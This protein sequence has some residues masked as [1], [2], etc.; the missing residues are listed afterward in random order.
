MTAV[1]A[2][3]HDYLPLYVIYKNEAA[4]AVVGSYCLVNECGYEN[5]LEI[6]LF[7]YFV[8][9]FWN[10]TKLGLSE[11]TSN[12]CGHPGMV[13]AFVYFPFD[14]IILLLHYCC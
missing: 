2:Q 9:L 12:L 3:L 13:L 8:D 10:P 11:S 1:Y 6:L 7:D 4:L 14:I 5:E